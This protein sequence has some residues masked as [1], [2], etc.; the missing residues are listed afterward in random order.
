MIRTKYLL[1][2]LGFLFYRVSFCQ[3]PTEENNTKIGTVLNNY[4]D[5]EREAIHLHIDK[6]TFINNESIWYQGYIINR[7]TEKPYFTTNVFVLLFDEKGNQLSEKLIFASNGTFSGK[8][9]LDSKMHSGNYYI[10]TYTNWMNNFSEN[11]STIT[12]VNIINPSEGVRNYKKINSESLEIF[13]NPE[14]KSYINGVSNI[15]GV[16][17]K[18]CRG[19]A[20]E[21]L[22]ASLVNN[23]GEILKSF[24][25]DKFGFGKFEVTPGNENLKVIVSY[26]DKTLEKALP[27]AENFGYS[28][29]VNNFTIE[30]KTIVKVKTNKTTANLMQN[31]KLYLLAH[32]DQ[33]YQI[34]DIQNNPNILEQTIFI[35]NADL[36]EGVNTI[37]IIDSD[38]KQ[39]AERLIYFYPKIENSSSVLKTGVKGNEM[40][41]VGYSPYPNSSLSVSVLPE[42]TK[43]WDESNNIISGITINPYLISSLENGNYYFSSMGRAKYYALDLCLLNQTNLKYQW[44]FMKVSAPSTKYSFDIGIDLKGTIDPKIQDKTFHKVKLSSFQYL[45]MLQSD[46]DEKGEYR[47]EHVLFV[48]STAV[49][50]SL[51][52]LPKF[53]EIPGKLTPQVINRKRPFNKPFPIKIPESCNSIESE[54]IVTDFN[55]PKFAGK[56]IALDEVTVKNEKKKLTYSTRLGNG[57]LRGY[58]VDEA[59]L[60]VT[61]LDFISSNGFN[62]VRDM[63]QSQIYS[64]L[65][66]SLNAGQATPDIYIDDRRLMSTNELDVMRMS[67]IDEIYLNPH[68]I[69]ASI[70]NNMGVIKIYTKKNNCFNCYATQKQNPNQFFIKDGYSHLYNFKNVEYDNTLSEGFDNCGLI[71]WLPRVTTDDTGQFLFDITDYNK[72]KGKIIIEGMTP[73]GKLFQEEKIIDL[74]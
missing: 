51:Q 7:K 67:E 24:K 37:R 27:A 30:G 52:K 39:W 45:L 58:K 69:V 47:F 14:G 49:N 59:M 29:E 2:F 66:T 23:D 31:K 46:V 72:A 3:T 62:V 44:D 70:N 57:N 55:L 11:E 73:E 16:Q 53:E 48:D 18:D 36:F 60:N 12:K 74:K 35:E 9:V 32:Q 1:L 6:T 26:N 22:E 64:R 17:L 15:V 10:Q 34:Y 28:I 40:N 71:E 13:L 68:A 4:F 54:S 42:G 50:L 5:L 8:I 25:L 41:M 20:P 21:N 43:S 56:I 63:G 38:M 33:K 19:N 65:K 61:L